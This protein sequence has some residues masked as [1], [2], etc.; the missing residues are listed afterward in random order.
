M[1]KG[2]LFETI[3]EKIADNKNDSFWYRGKDIARVQFPN[4]KKLYAEAQ[5][6][7]AIYFEEDGDKF[8]NQNAVD[9]A[10]ELGLTDE[11][12]DKLN[13]HD[14]WINNNWF[15]II[16]V[17]INGDVCSDDLAIGDDYDHAIELLK[18]VADEE[19][20]KMYKTFGK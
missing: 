15:C 10:I 20:E 19:F 4:G 1:R 12:L 11:D 16:M 18:Q 14:G 17:D 5:G 3:T 13:D 2:L 8:K 9:K 7:I 6:D